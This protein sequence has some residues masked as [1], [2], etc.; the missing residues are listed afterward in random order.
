MTAATIVHERV[1]PLPPEAK[2]ALDAVLHPLGLEA[3]GARGKELVIRV[4]DRGRVPT[5]N[6]RSALLAALNSPDA[7]AFWNQFESAAYN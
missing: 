1:K 5:T 3:C 4:V 6:F 7:A 2:A